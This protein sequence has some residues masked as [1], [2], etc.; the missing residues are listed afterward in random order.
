MAIHIPSITARR[1]GNAWFKI[2]SRRFLANLLL[3]PRRRRRLL[4][5][6]PLLAAVP[7]YGANVEAMDILVRRAA[8]KELAHT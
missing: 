5:A 8:R 6:R 7:L 1:I 4:Q 3:H 2:M